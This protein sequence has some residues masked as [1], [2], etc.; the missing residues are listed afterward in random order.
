MK[1]KVAKIKASGVTCFVNRQLIYNYPESLFAEAGIL[2]IEHADFEGVERLALVTGG[3]IAST[4]DEPDKVKLGRCD[5]IEEIMIGEDKVRPALSSL[6]LLRSSGS[7]TRLS[8][9]A[10]AAHQVLGRRRRRGVHGRP[11][12]CDGPDDRRGRPLAARRPVGPEPNGQGDARHARRRVRRDDHGRRRRRGGQ[13]HRGQ[14]GARRRGVCEGAEAGASGLFPPASSSRSTKLLPSSSSALVPVEGRSLDA[15]PHAPR[16]SRPS[17]PTT[18]G[19]TRATSSPSSVR[20]ITR[21]GQTLGLVR[22]RCLSLS[23][24]SPC[25]PLFLAFFRRLSPQP[26][27]SS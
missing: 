14:E 15:A 11:A 2:S 24:S 13:A 1:A 22:R 4:F 25:S 9:C 19:T 3:E 23:P 16:R 20:H 26:L 5:T 8:H 10:L 18:P 27:S 7:L 21:A 12:R 6:A 17:W